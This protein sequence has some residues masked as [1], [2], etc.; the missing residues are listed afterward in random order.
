MQDT[1]KHDPRPTPGIPTGAIIGTPVRLRPRD[2]A[3]HNSIVDSFGLPRWSP[4]GP[5]T[6][7]RT[8][9]AVVP[10]RLP[11]SGAGPRGTRHPRR[12]EASA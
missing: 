11:P 2:L 4:V 6:S 7:N 5:F 9:V 10:P 12:L 1:P 3:N 8:S